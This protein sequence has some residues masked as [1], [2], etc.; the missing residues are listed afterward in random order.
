M[1]GGESA[2]E[3]SIVLISALEWLNRNCLLAVSSS[4]SMGDLQR[5]GTEK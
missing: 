4:S 5:K 1:M 2:N 3:G